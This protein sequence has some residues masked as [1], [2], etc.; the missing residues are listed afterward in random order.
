MGA[1]VIKIENAAG[2]DPA[3]GEGRLKGIPIG[4]YNAYFEQS[5]CGKRSIAMDLRNEK[6]RHLAH[7]LVENSDVFVTKL[8]V[9]GME[10]LG[11]DYASLSGV[12]PGLIYAIGTGWGFR[13][14]ARN[15]GA[16]EATWFCHMRVGVEPG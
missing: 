10:R 3:R 11:M 2:G 15:R 9:A 8:R 6:A 4:R 16:F 14:P 12:N 13:G 1:E 5:N 7:K